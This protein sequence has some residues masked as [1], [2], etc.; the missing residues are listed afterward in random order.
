[1]AST[2][3]LEVVSA[4][5]WVKANPG[6]KEKALEDALQK[7][8]WDP[9]VKS[10]TAFPQVLH[11]M[12]EKLDLTQRLGDAFL[13]QQKDVLDAIQRL[14]GKADQAGNL[15]SGKEQTVTSAQEGGQTVIKIE[16]SNPRSST[17]RPT[18]RRSTAPGRTRLSAVL[19]LPAGLRP[20]RRH[21]V[22]PSAVAV[23]VIIGSAMWGNCNWG[24]GNVNINTNRYNNFNRTNVKNGN[25]QHNAE[26]RGGAGYR[27]KGSQQRYGGGQR[28]GVDSREQFRGRAEQGRQDISRGGGA[29]NFQGGGNRQG[30]LATARRSNL[31][32]AGL[33]AGANRAASRAWATARRR[34]TSAAGARAAGR[35]LTAV[36][37]VRARVAAAAVAGARA[38]AV[39]AGAAAAV[40]AGADDWTLDSDDG[41]GAGGRRCCCASAGAGA[42]ERQK[43]YGIARRSREGSRRGSPIARREGDAG[44][45]RP[46]SKSLVYSGD[47][48]ADRAAQEQFV[49]AYDEANKLEMQG[50]AK[51]ILSVGKDEWPFPIP[52]VKIRSGVAIRC[53]TGRGGTPQPAHRPQRARP[54]CRPCRPTWTPSASTTCAIRR[55]TSCCSTRS[56]SRAPRASAT[57][58]ISPR[59]TASR[60]A[61]SGRCSRPGRRAG[62][63]A[64]PDK[65]DPYYGYRYRILKAQGPDAPGGAYD[66]V[67]RG[68][69]I[70]GFALVAYP[71]TY[72]SS[73]IMTFIVN[74]EGVVYEKDLGPATSAIASK[75]TKFNPDATWK[76]Q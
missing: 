7:Q 70:G 57:A 10:L 50:D 35:V 3:P 6:L 74:H 12:N 65:P 5:R 25:W 21:A 15:K 11:M 36:V 1:M 8:T 19:L 2:Y 24:G 62:Q 56:V 28:A 66:Y 53:E 16:P 22:F 52:I 27:D 26:H 18:I 60:R 34:A 67:V 14:R 23:G 68:K 29:G 43:T 54:R 13:A 49:K 63:G 61:R 75:M 20:A 17:C 55:R 32:A 44:C 39:V 4:A 42:A 51:A 40:E 64:A 37:A 71:A 30:D 72:G 73:G 33:G 69:M 47:A 76:R 9:S 46:G 38:A 31:P 45:A 58:C 59:A 48:V 41:M